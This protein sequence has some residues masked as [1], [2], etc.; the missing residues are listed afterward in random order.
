MTTEQYQ[1]GYEEGYQEGWNAA[2]DEGKAPQQEPVAWLVPTLQTFKGAERVHFT[3]APGCTMT[4][5][6]LIDHME[7]RVVWI[8]KTFSDSPGVTDRFGVE[9]KPKPLYTAPQPA[10][11]PLSGDV[12]KKAARYDFLRDCDLDYMAE[13]Y[14]PGRQV[15]TG[16]ELDAAIDAAKSAQN[17]G[18]NVK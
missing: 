5:A 11:A 15:P 10:P 16:D 4:D 13:M 3:R 8:A 18:S 7:G 9:H 12:L 14:W 1:T 17:G 2:M 6:E